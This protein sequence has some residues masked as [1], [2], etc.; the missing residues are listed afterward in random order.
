MARS[1]FTTIY[2]IRHA[3][4]DWQ[5]NEVRPLSE[6]GI[7]G[8]QGVGR[9]L[10]GLPI[11]AIYSSPLARS[12][13]TVTPLADGLGLRPE[14]VPDLRER[15]LPI[16]PAGE[17]DR[18]VQEHWRSPDSATA[19]GESNVIAQRRGIAVLRSVTTRHVGEHVVVSTH[20]NLLALMLNGLDSS[21]GTTSGANSRFRTSIASS[22]RVPR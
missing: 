15:E 19:G 16:V 20:G 8:A 5:R 1:H 14:L 9:L 21:F 4:A 17:F 13:E 12:V 6:G 22:S 10:S 11:T 3:H 7:N 18:L 2:L